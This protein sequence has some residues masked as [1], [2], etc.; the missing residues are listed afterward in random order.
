[1][2]YLLLEK[3]NLRQYNLTKILCIYYRSQFTKG[4]YLFIIFNRDL[5]TRVQ[6]SYARNQNNHLKLKNNNY[7]LSLCL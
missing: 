5:I 3:S 7:L 1:M 6:T 4:Y 2:L